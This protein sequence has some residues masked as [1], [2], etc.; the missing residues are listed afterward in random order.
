MRRFDT[1]VHWSLDPL[2]SARITGVSESKEGDLTGCF[3]VCVFSGGGGVLV[4]GCVFGALAVGPSASQH[5][6]QC[7]VSAVGGQHF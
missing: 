2:A 3:L 1:L 4:L 7:F 5:C 6:A